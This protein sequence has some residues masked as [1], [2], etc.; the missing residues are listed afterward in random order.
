M[1]R[2]HTSEEELEFENDFAEWRCTHKC[3]NCGSDEIPQILRGKPY[4]PFLLW[5]RKKTH[6]LGW[7]TLLLLGCNSFE[8]MPPKPPSLCEKC[9][10]N[11]EGEN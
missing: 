5:H 4:T 10:K 3:L 7:T 9:A 2:D 11:A 6:E 1:S 8:K